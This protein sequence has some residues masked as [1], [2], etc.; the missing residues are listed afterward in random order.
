MKSRIIACPCRKS[1]PGLSSAQP[2][3]IS[4]ELFLLLT[5]HSR[6]K[7]NDIPSRNL[8][9]LSPRNNPPR[10]SAFF[11]GDGCLSSRQPTPQGTRATHASTQATLLALLST[12]EL[13]INYSRSA[14]IAANFLVCKAEVLNQGPTNMSKPLGGEM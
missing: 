13:P 9:L 12:S 3:T 11:P 14:N 6:Q 4:A 2:V 10:W 5:L 8:F 1:N 7:T